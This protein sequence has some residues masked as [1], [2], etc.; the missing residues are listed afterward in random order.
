MTTIND[1]SDFINGGYSIYSNYGV[2]LRICRYTNFDVIYRMVGEYGLVF[3]DY[4]FRN[5]E[6]VYRMTIKERNE[7]I[8]FGKI[9]PKDIPSSNIANYIPVKH[10]KGGYIDN[11]PVQIVQRIN[12]KSPNG[13]PVFN[14]L[15]NGNILGKYDFVSPLPFENRNGNFVAE[16]Y[17]ASGY[18]YL[19]YPNTRTVRKKILKEYFRHIQ[20]AKRTNFGKHQLSNLNCNIKQKSKIKLSQIDLY[21][22]IKKCI[23]EVFLKGYI[24]SK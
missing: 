3:C 13:K 15:Y 20:S 22:I 1:L 8:K 14:Y 16:A 2:N 9:R 23:D 18:C 24:Y 12:L 10:I 6:F 4:I 17:G 11:V 19:I 5:L 21:R 7:L